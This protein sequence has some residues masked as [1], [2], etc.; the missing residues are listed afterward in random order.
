MNIID[1][2]VEYP[3]SN[4]GNQLAYGFLI[5]VAILMLISIFIDKNWEYFPFIILIVA[6]CVMFPLTPPTTYILAEVTDA[7]FVEVIQKYELFSAREKEGLYVF[8][9][10]SNE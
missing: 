5:F 10:K 3:L 6:A 7:P 9:V 4:T 8:K 2:W 1:T